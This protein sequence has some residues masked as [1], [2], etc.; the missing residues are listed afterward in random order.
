MVRNML[1]QP[2]PQQAA[3]YQGMYNHFN[4]ELFGGR[5][6]GV[7]LN[8]SRHAK[9]LGFFAPERWGRTKGR[10]TTHEISLNPSY[11]RERGPYVTASTLVH[12]MV[13]LWQQEFGNPSRRGYH[14]HEWATKMEAVGLVPSSTGEPGGNRVGQ[15]VTHYIDPRGPFARAY[16]VMPKACLLPWECVPEATVDKGGKTTPVARNKIKYTC[17]GCGTNVWGKPGLVILCGDC[18][19]AFVA[20]AA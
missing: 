10:Q 8:F 20:A 3:A 17:G 2:T 7:I 18:E 11:M 13:H 14:N 12:E 9:S 5:L 15:K 1:K 19:A 16:K 6:P 4:A